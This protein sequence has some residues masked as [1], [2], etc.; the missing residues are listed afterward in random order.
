M[1][2]VVLSKG[3]SNPF[4]ILTKIDLVEAKITKKLLKK[5]LNKKQI[6]DEIKIR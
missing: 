4:I 1:S 5:H 2:L 3:Y 6:D